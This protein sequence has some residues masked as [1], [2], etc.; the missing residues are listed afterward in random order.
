MVESQI[1]KKYEVAGILQ[2]FQRNENND[3]FIICPA[4]IPIENRQYIVQVDNFQ[5][6]PFT[7]NKTTHIVNLSKLFPEHMKDIQP[8]DPAPFRHL[9]VK[10]PDNAL[11]YVNTLLKTRRSDIRVDTFRSPTPQSPGNQSDHT[12]IQNRILTELYAIEALERRDPQATQKTRDP[13]LSNI[14]S[15]DS[16]LDQWTK[17]AKENLLVRFSDIFPWH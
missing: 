9:Q 17:A 16:T 7:L 1:Y 13:F 14:D 5:D 15:A 11:Q 3:E 10:I 2:S 4:I 8:I 6:H 12:P